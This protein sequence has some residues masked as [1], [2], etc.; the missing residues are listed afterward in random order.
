MPETDL[1]NASQFEMVDAIAIFNERVGSARWCRKSSKVHARPAI[2]GELIATKVGVFL[3]TSNVAKDGDMVVRNLD[4]E[5]YVVAR[6]RF[7]EKYKSIDSSKDAAGF[8]THIPTAQ[9]VQCVRIDRAIEFIAPWGE[10]MRIKF[11]GYLIRENEC[12]VYGI[13]PEAFNTTYEFCEAP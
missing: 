5:Q 13:Q 6:D 12:D 3:E 7:I 4:G 1:T 2:A 11:G 8:I 10:F 9:P